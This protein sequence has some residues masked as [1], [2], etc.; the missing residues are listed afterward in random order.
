MRANHF[1]HSFCTEILMIYLCSL[2]TCCCNRELYIMSKSHCNLHEH[3]LIPDSNI[4]WEDE[5]VIKILAN[6][7]VA[8]NNSFGSDVVYQY[9]LLCF[10]IK[11][12]ITSTRH[13]TEKLKMTIFFINKQSLYF[14]LK[15]QKKAKVCNLFHLIWV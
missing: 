7:N 3:N 4:V 2:V 8:G 1:A 13:I 5:Y 9:F 15:I 11:L 12:I 6:N 10:V 14:N